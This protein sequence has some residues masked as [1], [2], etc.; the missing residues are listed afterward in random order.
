VRSDGR[1]IMLRILPADRLI[2]RGT[3]GATSGGGASANE[4]DLLD[5]FAGIIR[6][7]LFVNRCSPNPFGLPAFFRKK[8]NLAPIQPAP[9]PAAPDPG[10]VFDAAL[11]RIGTD[12]VKSQP[13]AKH[14][15]ADDPER[16]RFPLLGLVPWT[17]YPVWNSAVEKATTPIEKGYLL[18]PQLPFK[19]AELDLYA[20]SMENPQPVLHHD[21]T[22]RLAVP[23]G[24][25]QARKVDEQWYI[26]RSLDRTSGCLY[27]LFCGGNQPSRSVLEWIQATLSTW[28]GPKK[29]T[30]TVGDETVRLTPLIHPYGDGYGDDQFAK[31]YFESGTYTERLVLVNV[32]LVV[33]VRQISVPV[34][35]DVGEGYEG[36]ALFETVGRVIKSDVVKPELTRIFHTLIQVCLAKV[37]GHLQRIGFADNT[38]A[39]FNFAVP[40]STLQLRNDPD[41]LELVAI[42]K[43][44]RACK[45]RGLAWPLA[46]KD[47]VC[48]LVSL[49]GRV[50]MLV[51]LADDLIDAVLD[52]SDSTGT[53]SDIEQAVQVVKYNTA[54]RLFRMA[55]RACRSVSG[56]HWIGIPLEHNHRMLVVTRKSIAEYKTGSTDPRWVTD[57]N[58]IH[59]VMVQPTVKEH[60][61]ITIYIRE[62]HGDRS[63]VG[64]DGNV[65]V[66]RSMTTA[67]D[68][69]LQWLRR[70][71][72]WIP[73]VRFGTEPILADVNKLASRIKSLLPVTSS[74]EEE[75]EEEDSQGLS[76]Q[77]QSQGSRRPT[78][79]LRTEA[80]FE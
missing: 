53:S 30:G 17:T 45:E 63:Q 42:L 74:Q 55:G 35:T 16:L 47:V 48:H 69:S 62:G 2:A 34:T 14:V 68:V 28:A 59:Y 66:E 60:T 12:H 1:G 75:E 44:L 37:P 20:R 58:S 25:S 77:S 6:H 40:S 11:V 70:L 3:P 26:C 33:R 21:G 49:I 39:L 32:D 56:L 24:S 9:I 27:T 79:K 5:R 10:T 22:I 80:P 15:A 71:E 31:A 67:L 13:Y 73:D 18:A 8:L 78:K 52:L 23:V 19:D 43:L 4:L 65:C 54:Q 36:D 7:A 38:R 29:I 76:S 50:V 46:T 61:A 64:R 57:H 72:D 51:E 41:H